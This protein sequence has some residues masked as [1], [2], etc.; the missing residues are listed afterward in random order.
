MILWKHPLLPE[1]KQITNEGATKNIKLDCGMGNV[2]V[3]FEED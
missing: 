3:E 2:E 1:N